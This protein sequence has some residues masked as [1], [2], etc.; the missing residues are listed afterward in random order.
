MA[1]LY[2]K[3]AGKE[4]VKQTKLLNSSVENNLKTLSQKEKNTLRRNIPVSR[5][6]PK[7]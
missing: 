4:L 5:Q 1:S 7:K 2:S 6:N 3:N